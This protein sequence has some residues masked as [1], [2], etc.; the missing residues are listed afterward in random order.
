MPIK[1][2][3]KLIIEIVPNAIEKKKKPWK[4]KEDS[5]KKKLKSIKAKTKDKEIIRR[6]ENKIKHG[7]I[8]KE[9]IS[10]KQ[11][12]TYEQNQKHYTRKFF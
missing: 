8:E 5:K 10:N 3:S 7:E 11:T 12:Y 4:K 1:N 9:K 2:N 6:W